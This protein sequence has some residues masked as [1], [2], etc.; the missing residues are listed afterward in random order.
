MDSVPVWVLTAVVEVSLICIGILVFL[1]W[2]AVRG[3]RR[4]GVKMR[5]LQRLREVPAESVVG[6]PGGGAVEN[7]VTAPASEPAAADLLALLGDEAWE[8][9]VAGPLTSP[10]AGAESV[11]AV[12]PG[13]ASDETGGE[14]PALEEAPVEPIAALSQGMLDDLFASIPDEELDET[15]GEAPALEEAPEEPIVALSQEMLN[16]LFAAAEDELPQEA[17]EAEASHGMVALQA[18]NAAMEE[19]ING[20]Q[21]KARLLQ[22]IIKTL[23]SNVQLPR[24]EQQEVPVPEGILREMEEGLAE[25]QQGRERLYQ[26]FQQ[27]CR[28]R[29]LDE[30]GPVAPGRKLH[31][32]ASSSDEF[33]LSPEAQ[34]TEESWR[35]EIDHLESEL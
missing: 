13:Q 34:G 14:A 2:L 29:G 4:L 30:I 7:V 12:T 35:Q 19:Q 31:D 3:Q 5:E 27:Y 24:E 33:G 8:E 20:L 10:E 1:L 18:E 22:K 15:G 6:E 11:E 28:L 16:D 23:Q 21:A 9:D 17:D 32:S 26:E 25:L